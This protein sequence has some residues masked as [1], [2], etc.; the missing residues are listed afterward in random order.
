MLHTYM[1]R[2]ALRN[3][4]HVY[5]VG[6]VRGGWST[7]GYTKVSGEDKLHEA[8]SR[9]TE[10]DE[11]YFPGL[12]TSYHCDLRLHQPVKPNIA[13][14]VF[15][16]LSLPPKDIPGEMSLVRRF[17]PN[18]V[19][20]LY[21][22]SLE[23]SRLQCEAPEDLANRIP[24]FY[25]L[26][27]EHGDA[28]DRKLRQILD[29][30]K[31][32][33]IKRRDEVQYYSCFISYNHKDEQFAVK[34]CEALQ[35]RGIHCW[36]DKKQVQPGEKIHVSVERA[37]RQWDKLLLCASRDSLTSWWVENEINSA[38]AK[39][40]ELWRLRGREVLVLIP[41]DLDGYLLS[42]D[43]HSGW[44][45]QLRSRLAA[46]FRDWS[47]GHEEHL[48]EYLFDRAFE[49]LVMALRSD[50][51]ASCRTPAYKTVAA[52]PDGAV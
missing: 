52:H 50:E 35:G 51:G 39:E 17:L 37:I 16:S 12:S 38:I 9:V 21:A 44:K 31:L 15:L 19:F 11:V 42:E 33:A 18:A 1:T 23:L 5:V 30:A 32:T 22:D 6:S 7:S 47:A 49:N 34:L 43:W 24:H 27:K 45:N 8:L 41:L 2:D 46:N 4:Q 25:L 13:A 20:V 40:Q 3:S 29:D 10:A 14:V 26:H 48:R 36:L 28:F